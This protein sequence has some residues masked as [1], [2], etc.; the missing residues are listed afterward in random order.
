V[1][2]VGE[3]ALWVALLM[4][5][6]GAIVLLSGGSAA[7]PELIASGERALYATFACVVLATAGLLVAL[8]TSDF[9]F[10]YVASVTSANLPLAYK[11]VALWAGQAGMLLLWTLALSMCAAIAVATGRGRNRVVMPYVGGTLSL[12]LLFFLALL[13]L[14]ANPYERLA[15]I[16]AEGRGMHPGLQNPAMAV[17]PPAL[18][19]GYVATTIPFAFAVGALLARQLDDDWRV[20]VRRWGSVSWFFMTTGI[21]AGMWWAYV[22]PHRGASWALNSVANLSVVPWLAMT[23]FLWLAPSLE[24]RAATAIWNVLL[25]ILA[26]LL[27]LATTLATGRGTVVAVRTSISSGLNDWLIAFLVV[28]VLAVAYLLATRLSALD[29]AQVTNARG[30]RMTLLG[31]S[32]RRVGGQILRVGGIVFLVALAGLAFRRERTVSVRPGEVVTLV[33]PYRREWTFASQGVSRYAQLNRGVDAVAV[34]AVRSGRPVGL[35]RSEQRQYVD[36]RGVPTFEPTIEAGIHHSLLQDTYVV[37]ANVIGDRAEL[38]IAF[39]PLVTWVWIGGLAIAVGGTMVM[40][41]ASRP[42]RSAG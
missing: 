27:S 10:A 33:D 22:E 17:H 8:T 28:A 32:G 3:L 39:N 35:I 4:A 12:V 36:A 30:E 19:L 21:I 6:W 37:L 18:Y 5:A 15:S 34:R 7:R 23:T 2:L 11:V 29:E 14:A 9:S 38:R 20:A 16:P 41:P 31:T 24:T 42:L 13:C 1:I 26:F 40:W 25:V